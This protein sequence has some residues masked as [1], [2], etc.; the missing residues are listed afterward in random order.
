M[1][2]DSPQAWANQLLCKEKVGPI[3]GTCHDIIRG[4]RGGV[5]GEKNIED[6]GRMATFCMWHVP[7][8]CRRVRRSRINSVQ[9][10]VH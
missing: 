4:V 9:C 3:F 10:D 8:C 5:I 1:H 2:L 6:S 7:S